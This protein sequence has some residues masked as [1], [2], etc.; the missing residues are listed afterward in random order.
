MLKDSKESYYEISIEVGSYVSAMQSKRRG[1]QK[2]VV[3][4]FKLAV[5]A[6]EKHEN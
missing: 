3:S 6:L 4:A 5:H 1:S 2:R